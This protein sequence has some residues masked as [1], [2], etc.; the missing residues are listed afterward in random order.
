MSVQILQQVAETR[1][2][3]YHLTKD[4]PIAQSELEGIVNHAVMHTPSSFNS[5]STR[6]IVLQGAEHEK[7]W[8]LTAEALRAIVSSEHF[9]ATQSKLNTFK[10]AAGTILFFED[11]GVVKELQEKFPLYT[12]NFPVWADHANAMA[13]YALWTTLAAAGVGA[14]LQHYNPVIDQAV[15]EAWRVSASWKLRA[16]MV[17][18][19]VGTQAGEKSFEPVVGTRVKYFS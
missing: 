19:G 10:A 2:S 5:Q 15:A 8:D 17:F 18:G 14:N 7:L 4:L 11:M 9:E 16:Q 6:L 1:R 3:V 13:Q 12:E